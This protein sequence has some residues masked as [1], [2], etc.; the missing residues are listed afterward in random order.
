MKRNMEGESNVL[1]R[2]ADKGKWKVDEAELRARFTAEEAELVKTV[3][4][5]EFP[6][7]EETPLKLDGIERSLRLGDALF[8]QLPPR[9]IFVS[10][11]SGKDRAQLTRALAT[12]RI[13]QREAQ[14]RA[15]DEKTAKRVDML[16]VEEGDLVKLVADASDKTW[17]PYGEM[18]VK[19]GI[20]EAE[21]VARWLND[22]NNPEAQIDPAI[23][24]KESAVRY[25]QLV[26]MLR[27][28]ITSDQVP[29]TVFG[30]GHSGAL[31]QIR[32]EQLGRDATSGDAPKFCE[33]FSFDKDGNLIETK[34]V[35]M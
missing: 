25:R 27:E 12:A 2:H 32:Y 3:L 17:T 24:P 18:M 29:V 5:T 8:E 23:H 30:A 4:A 31:G 28:Q 1:I 9:S 13:A 35:E 34:G 22:M 20:S 15:R 14:D 6:G 26:R 33:M 11:D 16:H 19:E 21:A 7:L 10:I